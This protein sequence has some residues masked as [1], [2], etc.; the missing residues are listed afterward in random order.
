[1]P[2][3]LHPE[4]FLASLGKWVNSVQADGGIFAAG[5]GDA[6]D[7]LGVRLARSPQDPPHDGYA[8]SDEAGVLAV[9]PL[10]LSEGKQWQ[11]GQHRPDEQDRN[12]P[13]DVRSPIHP[14]PP[15]KTGIPSVGS[16]SVTTSLGANTF[17][18]L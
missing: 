7:D 2:Q 1:M 6:Q 5:R 12:H 15:V 11:E 17:L 13:M 16:V 18:G 9:Y 4:K 8:V 3:G 10:W 14:V